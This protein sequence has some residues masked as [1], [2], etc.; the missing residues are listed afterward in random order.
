[1]LVKSK[2]MN[3]VIQV[4]TEEEGQIWVVLSCLPT[5]KL[6]GIYIPPNDSPYYSPAQYGALAK[7]TTDRDKVIVLGDFNARVATPLLAD[8]DGNYY[9]Y[10]GVQDNVVN[11]HGRTLLNICNNNGLTVANHLYHNGNLLGGDL[12]FRRRE[13]WISEIDLCIIKNECADMITNLNVDQ[14]IPRSYHAPL[15]ITVAIAERQVVSPAELLHRASAL[16]EP[17]YVENIQPSLPKSMQ[18]K[19]VDPDVLTTEL[20]ETP[21]PILAE[22]SEVC[23]VEAA[24][25]EGYR[26]IRAAAAAAAAAAVH[27]TRVTNRQQVTANNAWESLEPRW[28]RI[29]ETND[30]KMIWKFINWKGNVDQNMDDRPN[31]AQFKEHLENLLNPEHAN[32]TTSCDVSAAPYIPILDD[33]FTCE[34]LSQ[35]CTTQRVRP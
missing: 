25:T 33:L 4:D 31:E 29:L 7:H 5:L 32:T 6:G 19:T 2:L 12:S 3:S 24:V 35:H 28:R 13:H 17:Q 10:Q 22:N 23:D 16:G 11:E 34:E 20:Q 14:T 26:I 30:T 1:M 9:Q 21:T 18:Y 8:R 27:T 15:C